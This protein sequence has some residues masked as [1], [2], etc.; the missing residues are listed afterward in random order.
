M[1]LYLV[2][3]NDNED[4]DTYDSMVVCAESPE[5]AMSIH[6]EGF[7]YEEPKKRWGSWAFK[8]ESIS[9]VEIGEANIDQERGVILA[10][11]NAG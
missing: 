8:K 7:E 9:C 11:F 3:Q 10:S 1:K 5:D 2:S 4:Y 6:P